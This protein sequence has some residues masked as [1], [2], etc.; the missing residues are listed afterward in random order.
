MLVR[1]V[2]W[3][4]LVSWVQFVVWV[5]LLV[6]VL[7]IM[8]MVVDQVMVLF[9]VIWVIVCQLLVWCSVRYM[10]IISSI[11][12]NGIDRCDSVFSFL[13]FI[14]VVMQNRIL[15]SIINGWVSVLGRVRIFINEI[16]IVVVFQV[17]QF[18]LVK[19]RIKLVSLLLIFLKQKWF[20]SIVFRLLCVVIQFSD[21]VQRVSKVL[22]MMVIYSRLMM[23]KEMLSLLLVNIVL[24]KKVKLNNIMVM[25][26]MFLCL[27]VGVL[28]RGKLLLFD[29]LEFLVGRWV[30]I[31]GSSKRCVRK[32]WVWGIVCGV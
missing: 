1:M 32:N 5:V 7:K 3:L 18:S 22:L 8:V 19:L 29:I 28:M 2:V 4:E 10:E 6:K 15:N 9:G 20:I 12:I 17:Y 14:S 27:V 25:E 11:N 30:V 24:V 31:V 26:N 21:V 23:E 13:Q 16:V